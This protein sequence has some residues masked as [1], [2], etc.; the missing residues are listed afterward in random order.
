MSKKTVE[1][2]P[3]TC[4][5]L[6][7]E[8]SIANGNL[9]WKR[10]LSC[11]TFLV[12]ATKTCTRL[13]ILI[14]KKQTLSLLVA[15]D[16]FA[17]KC[18]RGSV[19]STNRTSVLSQQYRNKQAASIAHR[20]LF[21][22]YPFQWSANR[23]NFIYWSHYWWGG[24]C[25][26]PLPISQL[27]SLL[28][29]KVRGTHLAPHG[30]AFGA[31]GAPDRSAIAQVPIGRYFIW[32]LYSLNPDR[33]YIATLHLFNNTIKSELRLW[34]HWLILRPDSGHCIPRVQFEENPKYVW[35]L[36]K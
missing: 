27:G 25:S 23:N 19:S 29:S 28:K 31:S 11:R 34:K 14:A 4:S 8:A 35:D 13:K 6:Y 22:L 24:L 36:T 17:L 12:W 30:R 1:K 5:F 16:S 26:F 32:K 21:L 9:R 7:N 33:L 2:T 15:C 20:T 10:C 18:P 3:D